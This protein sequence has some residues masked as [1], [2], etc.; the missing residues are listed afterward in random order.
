MGRPHRVLQFTK[1]FKNQLNKTKQDEITQLIER[2]ANSRTLENKTV[3]S[4]TVYSSE[5]GIVNC[6]R[7][8]YTLNL[9]FGDWILVSRPVEPV[10]GSDF[11]V[12]FE[13]D[14]DLCCF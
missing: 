1:K 2:D 6:S 8:N 5:F 7:Q 14:V 12:E 11:H 3:T 13:F 9:D 10:L 4:S